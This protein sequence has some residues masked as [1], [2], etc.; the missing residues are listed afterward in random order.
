MKLSEMKTKMLFR[1]ILISC[2]NFTLKLSIMRLCS[3]WVPRYIFA[4]K[5]PESRTDEQGYYEVAMHYLQGSL[6][7]SIEVVHSKKFVDFGV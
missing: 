7:R 6:D 2:N 5:F 1:L 3:Y 4:K